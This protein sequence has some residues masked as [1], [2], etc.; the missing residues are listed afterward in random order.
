MR[1]LSHH[2]STTVTHARPARNLG[3]VFRTEL[4]KRRAID[5]GRV[6]TMLCRLP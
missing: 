4:T 3:T 5:L 6:A 2:A 1:H